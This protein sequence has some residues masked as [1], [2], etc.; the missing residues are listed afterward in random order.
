MIGRLPFF[1]GAILLLALYLPLH[2][3]IWENRAEVRRAT[4]AGYVLPSKF[5]RVLALGNQGLLSDF[6]F[7]KTMTFY[8]ERS[9]LKQP[10]TEEDWQFVVQSLEAV[11]DLDPYFLDP[12]IFAEGLLTWD[13]GKI[14][15]ANR[16]L[17]KGRRHRKWDWRLPFFIGFNHF[18][19]Q[20]DYEK[21]AEYLM[22]ASRL[23]GSYDFLPNLAA[24][25]A[26]YGGKAKTAILFL[27]G[28][29]VEA[30]DPR[31]R[32]AIEFRIEA[33]EKAS[34]LEELVAEFKEEKGREPRNVEEL[35]KAG[36]IDKLP[37]DPYGGKWVILKNGRVYSTSR[38]TDTGRQDAPEG[39]EQAD[40]ASAV[41]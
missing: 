34:M 40:R 4:A 36:L 13:A 11:T 17:E 10:M 2:G 15:A 31:L 30:K 12:Y 7:L 38:F 32:A 22:E 24:R 20:G 33:L 6:L 16:L 19:F 18:Y 26:Y 41:K 9:I 8:G 25:L 21:G 37:Q 35:V 14:E 23:P 3:K 5:S 39:S 28:M 1:A 27:K 29:L